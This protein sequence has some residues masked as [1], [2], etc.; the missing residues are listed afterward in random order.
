MTSSKI[1]HVVAALAALALVL[2][3]AVRAANPKIVT[4]PPL[5]QSLLTIPEIKSS[6]GKLQATIEL[7]DG[8]RTLWDYPNT[9]RCATQHLRYL[10]GYQGFDPAAAPAWPAGQEPLPGP[11]LRARVGDLVEIAFFN[12]IDTQSFQGA[13]DKGAGGTSAA[14]DQYTSRGG[15]TGSTGSGSAGGDTMPNCL[16]GSSTSNL[17]FHGTHTTPSTGLVHSADAS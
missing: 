17:H 11:T 5:Q 7:V 16:H 12:D 14:C 2:A 8:M 13:L 1:A 10:R 6:G 15:P 9:N 3:P 4:C